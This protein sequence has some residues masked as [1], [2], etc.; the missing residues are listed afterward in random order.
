MK[1]MDTGRKRDRR[2]ENL[3]YNRGLSPD[4]LK[5][6]VVEILVLFGVNHFLS[7]VLTQCQ[8]SQVVYGCCSK[9]F[10]NRL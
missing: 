8:V 5:I 9:I 6:Q 3:V 10:S 4:K 1:I 7:C 2:S